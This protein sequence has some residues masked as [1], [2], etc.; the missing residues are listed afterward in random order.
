M[1]VR[2]IIIILLLVAVKGFASGGDFVKYSTDNQFR[3]S[4]VLEYEKIALD[5][6]KVQKQYLQEHVSLSKA[7]PLEKYY[8]AMMHLNEGDNKLGFEMLLSSAEE[9]S[10]TAMMQLG[11]IYVNGDLLEKDLV[12]AVGWYLK[13]ATVKSEPE[14]MINLGL[15]YLGGIGVERNPIKAKQFFKDAA[16]LGSGEAYLQLAL[17]CIAEIEADNENTTNCEVVDSFKKAMEL[18]NADAG[19]KLAQYYLYGL[20]GEEY[21]PQ[22]LDEIV[23]LANTGDTEAEQV[24]GQQ[25]M[26]GNLVEK[27]SGKAAY[28]LEKAA[29]KGNTKAQSLLGRILIKQVDSLDSLLNVEKWFVMAASSGEEEYV[30]LLY[31]FY[32]AYKKLNPDY[33]NKLKELDAKALEQLKPDTHRKVD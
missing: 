31:R 13:A 7:N 14:A 25:Y 27:D 3:I 29:N 21:K 18:G 26:F 24:L 5:S 2:G 12:K 4:T 10:T 22:G 15:F 17:L 6:F 16:N 30:D 8:L 32:N 19:V 23:R 9:N 28:W 33:K 11:S 1:V 20:H